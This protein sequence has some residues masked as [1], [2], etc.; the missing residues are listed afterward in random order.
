M[1]KVEI[2]RKRVAKMPGLKFTRTLWDEIGAVATAGISE[3]I[4]KQQ[5]ASGAAIKK[6]SPS[7]QAEKAI[8]GW[9]ARSLIA[10]NKSFI[11]KS[12]K[13]GTDGRDPLRSFLWTT[14]FRNR[15]ISIKPT[16]KQWKN[17]RGKGHVG[18]NKLTKYVQE[19]GYVGWFDLHRRTVKQIDALIARWI[20]RK[21]SKMK[22]TP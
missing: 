6:N 11:R 5:Q 21:F 1:A 4:Q 10:K 2:I 16:T 13:K 22:G 7:W 3:N 17:P 14:D 9:D 8:R 18:F 12:K 20:K 15:F 19:K